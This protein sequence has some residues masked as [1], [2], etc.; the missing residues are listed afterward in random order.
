MPNIM[1]PYYM[2]VQVYLECLRQLSTHVEHVQLLFTYFDP[3]VLEPL[4]AK[5]A[6]LC[7]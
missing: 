4:H 6:C 5:S 1:D 2:Y 3:V 7:M